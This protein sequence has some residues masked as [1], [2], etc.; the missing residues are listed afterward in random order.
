MLALGNLLLIDDDP[1]VLEALKVSIQGLQAKEASLFEL[2][3]LDSV[4]DLLDRVPVS[5]ILTDIHLGEQDGLSRLHEWKKK[6]GAVIFAVSGDN[7]PSQVAR[8]FAVGADGF[9]SKPFQPPELRELLRKHF[10]NGAIP[11]VK[12]T[13]AKAP[14]LPWLVGQSPAIQ[15]LAGQIQ[16]LRG[17]VSL[18]ILIQG[19]SG[20][21]KERVARA[22][23]AQEPEAK[24]ATRDRPGRPWVVVNM[25]ALPPTLIE[26]ELFGVEKGAFTDAKV[27][28]PG[29]F[30]LADKGDLFLDE[31]GDLPLEAQAK[32]LRITQQRH[33]ERLGSTEGKTVSVR[34]IS[35]THRDLEAEI[36][37][38][39][40]R[41]DLY[42]RLAEV[43]LCVPALRDR[44]EDIPDLVADFLQQSPLGDGRSFSSEAL[45]ELQGYRWPGNVRELESALKR[46]LAFSN[47]TEVS[48]IE[49]TPHQTR[50][51]R[52]GKKLVKEIQSTE[53]KLVWNAWQKSDGKAD[54]A[55]R[56]LGVSKATFYR[57]LKEARDEQKRSE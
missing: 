52:P 5:V 40:F 50:A 24:S 44:L 6:T 51:A 16:R 12:P 17:K 7:R 30:E 29:K 27:S 34:L 20:T 47:D 35:A 23:H 48:R 38:K 25:A 28:R 22:L 54:L 33:V 42:F 19:E 53:Q 14:A 49:W 4:S 15:H 2:S 1:L 18:N 43:V 31:I 11:A 56:E 41:E 26:S 45:R 37:A 10:T 3:D 32:I 36:E 55:S 46:S 13:P 9:L 39:R 8:A 57:R 21:G